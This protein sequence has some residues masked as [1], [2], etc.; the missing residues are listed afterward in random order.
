MARAHVDSVFQARWPRHV[1]HLDYNF[2]MIT[3]G[4]TRPEGSGTFI[5]DSDTYPSIRGI[6]IWVD[7]REACMFRNGRLEIPGSSNSGGGGGGGGGGG[8]G[9]QGGGGPYHS[10]GSSSGGGYGG[11]GYGGGGYGGNSGGGS[12]S[13]AGGG[14]TSGYGY[15]KASSKDPRSREERR[16]SRLIEGGSRGRSSRDHDDRYPTTV[17]KSPRHHHGRHDNKYREPGRERKHDHGRHDDEYREPGRE[18]RHDSKDSKSRDREETKSKRRDDSL[19]QYL[20]RLTVG[21]RDRHGA[22]RSSRDVRK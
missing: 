3:P 21:S 11:G 19:A 18:R 14:D 22:S 5:V 12:Y 4:E 1:T 9:G 10:Y 6:V 20:S 15:S 7:N 13:G 17:I 2:R 16:P 8:R